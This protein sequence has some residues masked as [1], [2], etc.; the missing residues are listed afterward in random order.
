MAAISGFGGRVTIEDIVMPAGRWTV[1]WRGEN[2]DVST[3]E[4]GL[5]KEYMLTAYDIEVTLDCFW[6]LGVNTFDANGP[7]LLP[8]GTTVSQIFTDS[9]GVE[10]LYCRTDGINRLFDFPEVLIES[11]S[12]D[13]EVRGVIRYSVVGRVHRKVVFAAGGATQTVLPISVP[14]NSAPQNPSIP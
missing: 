7:N 5:L 3:F 12:V 9:V 14:H 6:D 11:V 4:H 8:G 1:N 13:D 2:V 10:L